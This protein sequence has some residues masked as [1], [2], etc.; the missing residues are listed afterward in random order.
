MCG[1]EL[2][3]GLTDTKT[4]ILSVLP[5]KGNRGGLERQ[6]R[7]FDLSLA[8]QGDGWAAE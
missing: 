3:P 4:L 6:A 5:C 8:E 2:K 7:E 1:Q